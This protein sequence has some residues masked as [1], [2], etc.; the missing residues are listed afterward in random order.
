MLGDSVIT[1]G[2][3]RVTCAQA[4]EACDILSSSGACAIRSVLAARGNP[5]ADCDYHAVYRPG[6]QDARAALVATGRPG[7]AGRHLAKHAFTLAVLR[8]VRAAACR[9]FRKALGEISQDERYAT[10]IARDAMA[11]GRQVAAIAA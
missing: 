8:E 5:L 6:L 7:G 1:I 11:R 4:L 2:G 9:A 3:V 10:A